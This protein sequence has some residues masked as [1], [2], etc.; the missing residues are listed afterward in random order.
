MAAASTFDSNAL[1][2]RLG[3]LVP[4]YPDAMLC[5]ALSGGV[6]SVA[7]LHAAREVTAVHPTL[8]L[9][10]VHVDHGLQPDSASW[11]QRCAEL[12]VRLSVPLDSVA[13]QLAPDKGESVEALARRERY[14]ALASL[15]AP[16]ECLLTAH[17]ADDQLETVLLQLFRGAGAAGLAAMP[18]SSGLGEGRHLR[19]LLVFRRESLVAYATALGLSWIDDPMNRESRF[20]RAYLRQQVLPAVRVRWPSVASTVGRSA[21]HLAAAQALLVGLA[22]DDGQS[23]LDDEGRLDIAGLAAL[24]RDRQANLLRWWLAG[25]GLGAPSTS[26]LGA[27]L[28]DVVGA[29]D[30]TRAVVTWPSGEVRRYRGRLYAMRPLGPPPPRGWTAV[31]AEGAEVMLPGGLGRLTLETT[32]GRGIASRLLPGP[33]EVRFR[34]AGA[35]MRPAGRGRK[36]SVSR[37]FQEAGVPSWQRERTPLLFAGQRPLAVAGLWVAAEVAATPGEA[38]LLPCWRVAPDGLQVAAQPPALSSSS[39]SPTRS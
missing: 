13:L 31:L 6:D 32:R 25:R 7:L 28:D 21:R 1:A 5:I 24:P 35:R 33:L 19:P 4:G 18:D 16:G 2:A 8:R 36:T 20:D 10:A 3:V 37:C 11:A 26:R 17:H 22:A 30:D 9:R 23:I 15:L 27:V 38:A 29:G 39:R 34:V 14:A 12:C